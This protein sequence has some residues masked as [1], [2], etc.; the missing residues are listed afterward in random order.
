MQ[1]VFEYPWISKTLSKPW[2]IPSPKSKTCSTQF[3]LKKVQFDTAVLKEVILLSQKIEL[4]SI[5]ISLTSSKILL[6]IL[7]FKLK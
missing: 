2:T 5:N 6:K 4:L 3:I 1:L 7:Q